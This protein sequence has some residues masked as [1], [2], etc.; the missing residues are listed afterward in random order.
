MRGLVIITKEN[1][2]LSSYNKDG[3]LPEELGVSKSMECTT[4]SI[5]CSDTVG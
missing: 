4:F 3:R 2:S 1:T 5:Q